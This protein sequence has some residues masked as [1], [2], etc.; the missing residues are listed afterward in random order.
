M[1]R[2]YGIARPVNL[3]IIISSQTA[4]LGCLVLAGLFIHERIGTNKAGNNQ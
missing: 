1:H 2:Q 3:N 4:D